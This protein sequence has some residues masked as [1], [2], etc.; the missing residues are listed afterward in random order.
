[1]IRVEGELKLV[2]GAR[3]PINARAYVRI[4]DVTNLDVRSRVVGE[5]TLTGADIK[6]ARGGDLQFVVSAT[7][8]RGADLVVSG[9]VDMDGNGVVSKGDYVSVVAYP[10]WEDTT[11]GLV[12]E[13]RRVE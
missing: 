7:A 5:V 6:S 12:V 1:M 3:I 10:V 11:T 2:P 4:L 13:L 8:N 9:F